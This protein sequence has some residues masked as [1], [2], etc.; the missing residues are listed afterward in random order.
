MKPNKYL[1]IGS[2]V[3]P[4]FRNKRGKFIVYFLL[5]G[6]KI[7]YIGRTV[8]I[9][10]RIGVHK[11]SLW[12]KRWFTYCRIIECKSFAKMCRYENRWI[13]KFNPMYN[14]GGRPCGDDLTNEEFQAIVAK[15]GWSFRE[16]YRPQTP[17]LAPPA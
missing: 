15:H 14:G 12:I 13:K 7:V 3:R 8:D 6:K 11:S 4:E 5:R 10:Q 2:G 17:V 9:Q 1:K 16:T